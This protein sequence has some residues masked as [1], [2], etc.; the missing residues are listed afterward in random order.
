MSTVIPV[1]GS[2]GRIH[3]LETLHALA[4]RVAGTSLP[5]S[6]LRETYN[7]LA[8]SVPSILAADPYGPRVTAAQ[9]HA[10]LSVQAR[11]CRASSLLP[12]SSL[13]IGWPPLLPPS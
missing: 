7:H 2:P 6:K 11:T 1:H 4:G 13:P 12:T 5:R 8:S 10:A 9:S 3:F